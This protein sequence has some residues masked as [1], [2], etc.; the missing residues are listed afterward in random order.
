MGAYS[1]NNTNPFTKKDP[2]QAE[3]EKQLRKVYFSIYQ[4]QM[5][6]S[7]SEAKQ[8]FDDGVLGLLRQDFQR[9]TSTRWPE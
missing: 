3:V 1:I 9:C 5:G 4:S 8:Y 7:Y 2:I 6:M